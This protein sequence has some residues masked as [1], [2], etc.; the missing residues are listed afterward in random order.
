MLKD[1]LT[2][3]GFTEKESAIYLV[4]AEIGVQPA[5]VIAR[6]SN[7]DRVTAYKNLKK[8]AEKGLVKVYSRG[9]VQCFGIE[10][11]DALESYI[12]ER[13]QSSSDL[14]KRF[15]IVANVLKSLRE[16]EDTVPRLH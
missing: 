9:S 4:L 12:N 13:V 2:H 6:R 8:L 11:F 7:L 5:S 1:Y 16:G 10:S 14:Q 15:P 3:L